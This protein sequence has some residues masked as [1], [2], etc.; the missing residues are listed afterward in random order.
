M[1]PKLEIY[2]KK[3]FQQTPNPIVKDPRAL[4]TNCWERFSEW[5]KGKIKQTIDLRTEISKKIQHLKKF[6]D[7]FLTDFLENNSKD[8]DPTIKGACW[9]PRTNCCKGFSGKYLHYQLFWNS[10]LNL[11]CWKKIYILYYYVYSFKNKEKWYQNLK[12]IS[13]KYFNKPGANHQRRVLQT[14]CLKRFPGKYFLSQRT[15]KLHSTNIFS[16]KL[17]NLALPY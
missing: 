11:W 2:L 12:P 8:P 13:R 7:F 4:K 16:R 1:I 15:S 6:S 3:I 17:G 9:V 14:N 10:G 5:E